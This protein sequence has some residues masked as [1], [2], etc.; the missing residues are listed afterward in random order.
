[1]YEDGDE[2]LFTYAYRCACIYMHMCVEARG[3]CKVFFSIVFYL[4][5]SFTELE[6]HRVN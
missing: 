6:A 3:I 5:V 2:Y 1:M 4:T